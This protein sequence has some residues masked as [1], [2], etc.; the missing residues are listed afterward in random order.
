MKGEGG[1][2]MKVGEGG[3]DEDNEREAP[4]RSDIDDC[5]WVV[6]RCSI[7]DIIN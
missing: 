5:D 2:E 4:P 7:H 1:K 6:L 3:D